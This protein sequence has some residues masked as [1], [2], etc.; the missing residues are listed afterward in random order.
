M[1]ALQVF[2]SIFFHLNLIFKFFKLKFWRAASMRDLHSLT[3]DEI[4]T[5]AVEAKF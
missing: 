5:P 3:K 1:Y 4:C 2:S